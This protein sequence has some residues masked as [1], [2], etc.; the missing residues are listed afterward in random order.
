MV[1][2]SL[3]V[4]PQVVEEQMV[5]GVKGKIKMVNP[6][7]TEKMIDFSLS[8]PARETDEHLMPIR[9]SHESASR[10]IMAN[11][12]HDNSFPIAPGQRLSA[13]HEFSVGIFGQLANTFQHVSLGGLYHPAGEYDAGIGISFTGCQFMPLPD[14]SLD[15]FIGLAPVQCT[16][17]CLDQHLH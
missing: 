3:V 7:K 11:K 2:D 5:A 10:Q 17:I 6:S 8:P 12:G 4:A 14:N 16:T 15:E 13:D 9:V 1:S